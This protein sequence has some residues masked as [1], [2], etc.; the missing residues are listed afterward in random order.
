MSGNGFIEDENLVG[1]VPANL[2]TI[3]SDVIKDAIFYFL[4]FNN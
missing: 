4:L 3:Y 2:Y 1:S